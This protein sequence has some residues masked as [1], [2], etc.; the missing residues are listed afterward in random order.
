MVRGIFGA[1]N[2][3]ARAAERAS[4][5]QARESI[6]LIKENERHV[7]DNERHARLEEQLGKK[8]YLQL[9]NAETE[10]AN[11][12]LA[13][14]LAQLRTIL[15]RALDRDPSINFE[16][17]LKYPKE[18]DLDSDQTLRPFPKPNRES[19]LPKK[20]AF[21]AR[22]IPGV[23]KRYRASVVAAEQ[24]FSQK[25][26]EFEEIHRRRRN[27]IAVLYASA[28]EHNRS[29]KA[30]ETALTNNDPERLGIIS[31]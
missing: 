2:T 21:I 20:P 17:F 23:Q 1:I 12:Q 31:S 30:A 8:N 15:S 5:E 4:R 19:F 9:R 28:E 27:A 16:K 3:M 25:L 11:A 7:K 6:R 18:S 13:E 24:C 10:K 29:V 14:R 26:E 22:L